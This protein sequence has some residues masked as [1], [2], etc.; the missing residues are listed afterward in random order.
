MKL[1]VAVNLGNYENIGLESNEY[2]DIEECREELDK[3]LETFDEPRINDF[4]RK[5]L[6]TEVE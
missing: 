6:K 3:A 1:K 4:R 2:Y 5:I